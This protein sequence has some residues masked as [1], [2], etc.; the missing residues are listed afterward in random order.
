[1]V[2]YGILMYTGYFFEALRLPCISNSSYRFE[3]QMRTV[4]SLVTVLFGCCSF[5]GVNS[6]LS[7]DYVVLLCIWI[8]YDESVIQGYLKIFKIIIS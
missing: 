4:F 6:L 3:G 8:Y 7:T 5:I 1:M 2:V